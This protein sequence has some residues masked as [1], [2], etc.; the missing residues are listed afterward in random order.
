MSY[1]PNC[2][3]P[4]SST[5]ITN[6]LPRRH[7]QGKYHKHQEQLLPE[8]VETS[9][10][11]GTFLTHPAVVSTIF[12]MFSNRISG[13]HLVLASVLPHPPRFNHPIER[14]KEEDLCSQQQ[15]FLP[16]CASGSL[17]LLLAIHH[18]LERSGRGG[19]VRLLPGQELQKPY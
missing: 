10:D 5:V 7:W 18:P 8:R 19:L 12:Y 17:W 9:R 11:P 1:T 4:N 13:V 16:L 15:E 3:V 14:R 6:F 2:I